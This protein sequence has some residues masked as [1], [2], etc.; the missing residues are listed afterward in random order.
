M[1][2]YIETEKESIL[3]SKTSID[4][5]LEEV[6][7]KTSKIP[8]SDYA[9][10]FKV[11]ATQNNRAA[12]IW[13]T[14]GIFMI[15]T[16]VIY[17][18][19]FDIGRLLPSQTIGVTSYNIDNIVL[20]ILL[21]SIYIFM[22]S[23]SMKQFSINRHLATINKHRQNGFNSFILF[24]ESINKEDSTLR[25]ELILQLAKVVYEQSNTGYLGEKGS[26]INSSIVEITKMINGTRSGGH[27]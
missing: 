14:V 12:Y 16:F 20:K 15:L 3:N 6:R 9:A 21:F 23:F 18:F 25:H 11:Q 26:G 8:I 7:R 4:N 27:L 10:I 19:C 13:L 24:S 17:I 2:K 1:N 22:I 5:I